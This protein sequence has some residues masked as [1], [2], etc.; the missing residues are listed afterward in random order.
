MWEKDK[1]DA[2]CEEWVSACVLAHVNVKSNNISVWMDADNKE[3]QCGLNAS[4]PKKE[5]AYFGNL[6]TSPPTAFSCWGPNWIDGSSVGRMCAGRTG[7]PYV[8]MGLCDFSCNQTPAKDAYTACGTGTGP[9]RPYDHVITTYLH[10]DP[11]SK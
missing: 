10:S 7:C 8:S 11:S 3:I 1:C 5:G 9:A 2:D 6:F 4:F